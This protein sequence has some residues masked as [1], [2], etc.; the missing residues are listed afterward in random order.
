MR[1]DPVRRKIDWE[2]FIGKRVPSLWSVHG[3]TARQPPGSRPRPL[4]TL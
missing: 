4:T 1:D 3:S 2:Q